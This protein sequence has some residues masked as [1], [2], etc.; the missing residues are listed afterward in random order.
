MKSAFIEAIEDNPIIPAVK[1]E[2][3]LK[4]AIESD[5]GVV[6]IL[7]GDICNIGDIVNQV[8]SKGKLAMVH[9]DLIAGLGNKDV[10]VDFIKERTRA[11]GIITTKHNLAKRAKE[12]G[13]FTVLRFFVIDSL[14]LA[15]LEKQTAEAKPD[16]VEVLP[17]V[18][19]KVIKKIV[20][21]NKIPLIAGGLISDR[22]DVCNALDAGAMAVSSTNSR[23]WF[24]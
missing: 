16:C 14:A 10:S 13:L 17:G 5:I 12:I 22:E 21:K 15:N 11:D 23:I 19:P 3:S 1:D 24:M 6:F 8:K 4:E 2:Q 18:M 7:Y 20:D 9:M